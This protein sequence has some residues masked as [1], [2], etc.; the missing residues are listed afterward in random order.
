MI[1]CTPMDA[2]KKFNCVLLL[3]YVSLLLTHWHWILQQQNA[4]KHS[5]GLH[6]LFFSWVL[7]FKNVTECKGLE[8]ALSYWRKRPRK[9]LN[10]AGRLVQES[11]LYACMRWWH[12]GVLTVNDC[13]V[14]S[15]CRHVSFVDCP[16]HD[17]LMATMLN[18]AAVMDAALL[19]I[20][21]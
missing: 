15:V 9:S 7:V 6:R 4:P 3:I 21:Q 11:W 2:D 20:G 10:F 1:K 17:I 8:L 5:F 19:L 12:Y 18:G 14:M 13:C 16:G